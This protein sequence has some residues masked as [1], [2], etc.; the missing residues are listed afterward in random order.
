MQ[1]R[2]RVQRT[3]CSTRCGLAGGISRSGSTYQFADGHL[4]NQLE[5][6]DYEVCL[7]EDK[8]SWVQTHGGRDGNED[9]RERDH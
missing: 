9:I 3:E 4:E 7:A 5:S 6:I 1:S 2:T 8:W